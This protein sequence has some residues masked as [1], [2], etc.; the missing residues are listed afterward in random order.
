MT[1]R[2]TN[3]LFVAM[4]LVTSAAYS[5]DAWKPATASELKQIIPARAQVEKERI[6][7]ES[8]TASGITNGNG[9]FF[10]GV[11]LITAGYAAEGKYSNFIIAQVPIKIETLTL[12][13]GNYVFG[14][15]HSGEDALQVGFY[16]AESGKP[17]GTAEAKRTSRIG[18]IESFHISPPS[19]KGQIEIG[20]FAMPYQ[21]VQ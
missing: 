5:A 16:E 11:V 14:W 15:K 8:R 1:L 2:R 19:D 3:F 20:R 9:K 12:S 18:K 17:V 7:T 10:A 6:E 13:P 21:L 4:L